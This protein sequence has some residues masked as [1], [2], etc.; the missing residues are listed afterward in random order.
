MKKISPLKMNG[1]KIQVTKKEIIL[2]RNMNPNHHL[3]G[4]DHD[5]EIEMVQENEDQNRHPGVHTENV[6][7]E[8]D[9]NLA[10]HIEGIIQDH[11]QNPKVQ[12]E[13]TGRN[14]EVHIEIRNVRKNQVDIKKSTKI[15]V[16]TTHTVVMMNINQ[17]E[18]N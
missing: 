15:K 5:Q 17:T 12:K 14:Q 2:I 7:P 9:Q 13:N 4:K 11:D 1:Y 16:P 8:P 18:K 3:T 6:G 10:V